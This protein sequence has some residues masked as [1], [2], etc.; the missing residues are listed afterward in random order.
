MKA[1]DYLIK[2]VLPEGW[3][4]WLH[5]EMVKVDDGPEAQWCAYC[6][7]IEECNEYIGWAVTSGWTGGDDDYHIEVKETDLDKII[8]DARDWIAAHAEESGWPDALTRFDLVI[9]TFLDK[10]YD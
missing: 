4:V 3:G 6:L 9:K 2:M 1:S 8:R 5:D 10:N 7:I